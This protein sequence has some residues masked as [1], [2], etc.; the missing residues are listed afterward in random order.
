MRRSLLEYS[1]KDWFLRS[2]TSEE[3][4][5]GTSTPSSQRYLLNRKNCCVPEIGLVT[6]FCPLM[7]TGTGELVVQTAEEPR[8][9]VD[10]SMY[11]V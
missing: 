2:S 9:V 5:G 7:T 4:H 3:S 6:V 1:F 11:P 8:F 10:W